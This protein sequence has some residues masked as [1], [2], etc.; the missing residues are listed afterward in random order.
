VIARLQVGA[1][2]ET[3]LVFWTALL[4]WPAESW[5]QRLRL[6]AL[7][8]PMFFALVSVT[9]VA[10]LVTELSATSAILAGDPDPLTLWERWSRFLEAGG[11]FVLELCTALVVVALASQA[12]RADPVVALHPAMRRRPRHTL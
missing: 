3:P 1:A 5:E 9:T 6:L 12:R 8:I 7:G 11:R 4:L 10:Q 2:V